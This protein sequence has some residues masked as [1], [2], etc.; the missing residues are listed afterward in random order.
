MIS[1]HKPTLLEIRFFKCQFSIDD[2]HRGCKISISNSS[3]PSTFPLETPNPRQSPFRGV[4][5]RRPHPL[6]PEDPP[7]LRRPTL[8][9]AKDVGSFECHLKKGETSPTPNAPLLSNE[10]FWL[11]NRQHRPVLALA[12]RLGRLAPFTDLTFLQD[13]TPSPTAVI[14]AAR[15]GEPGVPQPATWSSQHSWQTGIVTSPSFEASG[16]DSVSPRLIRH[17]QPPPK[18][19]DRTQKE[20]SLLFVT[21]LANTFWVADAPWSF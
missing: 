13:G 18:L 17:M 4:E 9:E 12:G 2:G 6:Q 11:P 5:V 15:L 21:T 7:Q 10:L 8:R 19:E 14:T 20:K 1:L 3:H 16:N